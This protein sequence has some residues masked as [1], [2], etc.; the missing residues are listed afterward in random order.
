M[1][2]TPKKKNSTGAD[3]LIKIANKIVQ[4]I[5][6]NLSYKKWVRISVGLI[7]FGACFAFTK[8]VFLQA[9]I[10]YLYVGTPGHYVRWKHESKQ[11]FTYK[12]Y[13]WNIT[14]P[15]EFAMGKERPKL[16]EVG[17]YVFQ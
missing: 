1:N 12:L 6:K 2:N 16:A 17:P 4:R 7:V 11:K 5:P 13:L 8:P 14:N 3:M 10:R 15:A 9:I